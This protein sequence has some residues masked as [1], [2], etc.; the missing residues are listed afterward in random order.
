MTLANVA[1]AYGLEMT[2]GEID[3]DIFREPGHVLTALE[4]D[5]VDAMF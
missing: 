4:L 5:Y 2:K 1:G 3:Y